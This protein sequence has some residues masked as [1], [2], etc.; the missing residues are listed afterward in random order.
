MGLSSCSPLTSRYALAGQ[1]NFF[2]EC[3]L[4]R[5]VSGSELLRL[6]RGNGC[7]FG[8]LSSGCSNAAI[9]RQG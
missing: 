5:F 7:L 8:V 9:Q 3:G 4:L 2:T 1:E 6:G